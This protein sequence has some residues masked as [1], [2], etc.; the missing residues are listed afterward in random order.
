MFLLGP[1]KLKRLETAAHRLLGR[2][3][4][5]GRVLTQREIRSFAGVAN[6]AAPAVVDALLRLRELF[7]AI[8]E[9]AGRQRRRCRISHAGM[10]DLKWWATLSQSPFLGRKLWSAPTASVFTDASMSGWGAAW[11]GHVPASGFFEE[12][13]AGS[14]INELEVIAALYAIEHFARYARQN[15]VEIITDSKVALHTIRN[16]TSK[17]RIVLC[18]LRQLREMC[19]R[20]GV[21]LSTRHLPSI[22]NCWADRLSR[23]RDSHTWDMPPS[24]VALLQRQSRRNLVILDGHE[25]PPHSAAAFRSKISLRRGGEG[26]GR[27]TPVVVPRPSLLAAWVRHFGEVQDGLLI[28]PRWPTQDWYVQAGRR[29]GAQIVPVPVDITPQWGTVCLAFGKGRLNQWRLTGARAAQ[30]LLPGTELPPPPH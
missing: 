16:L 10:R 22:L 9:P 19:E 21:T 20:L 15:H 2:A 5:G 1:Q 14:H 30:T 4:C 26:F 23:R 13:H 18:R 7:N 25:L 8:A 11:N 29:H 27:R 6:A 3:S 28:A 17:S 12:E 24:A